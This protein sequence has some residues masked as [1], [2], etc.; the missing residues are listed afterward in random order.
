[1]KPYKVEVKGKGRLYERKTFDD[2]EAAEKHFY[3]LEVHYYEK[4]KWP[5]AAITL[6][7]N[8][9]VLKYT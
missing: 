6:K 7:K 3:F 5:H 1:M 4:L 9:E 8:K 2:L